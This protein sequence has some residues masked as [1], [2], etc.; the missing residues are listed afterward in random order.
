MT[1]G[2]LRDAKQSETDEKRRALGDRVRQSRLAAQLSQE[3]LARKAGVRAQ[4]ISRCERGR[5][6]PSLDA[7][8]GIADAT[9]VTLD[10]LARGE[11]PGPSIEELPAPALARTGG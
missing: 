4:T 6:L 8:E 11:G 5:A 1:T 9:G 10:W 3:E 7:L 2:L